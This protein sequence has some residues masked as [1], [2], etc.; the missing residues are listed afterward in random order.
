MFE[1]DD[2]TKEFAISTVKIVIGI[3]C[4]IGGCIWFDKKHKA[5]K[6]ETKKE[7]E[8]Q[9][10]KDKERRK[11]DFERELARTE[12]DRKDAEQRH[13]WEAT[14]R[15]KE[16]AYD[17][18]MKDVPGYWDFR[19]AQMQAENNRKIEEAK[20]KASVSAAKEAADAEVKIAR[21]DNDTACRIVESNNKAE[22]QKQYEE[23][24]ARRAKYGAVASSIT[25]MAN[26]MARAQEAKNS[27]PKVV[28][29]TMPAQ[30]KEVIDSEKT[31]QIEDKNTEE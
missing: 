14:E 16:R 13:T 3:G 4:I 8:E 6:E 9:E 5:S 22:I 12:Q 25:G 11:E 17:L 19:T 30:K 1:M 10:R 7:L 31:V 26:A 24:A 20:A 21:L 28:N 15:E 2:N 23:N 18:Q 29:I 27:S